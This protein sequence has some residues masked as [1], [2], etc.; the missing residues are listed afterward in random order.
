MRG[1]CSARSVSSIYLDLSINYSWLI[2]L[3]RLT[4]VCLMSDTPLSYW[5]D[6]ANMYEA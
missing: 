4:L 5:L 3:S 6:G 2:W 1:V